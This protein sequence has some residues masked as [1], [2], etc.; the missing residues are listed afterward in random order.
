[1]NERP[2]L[3]ASRFARPSEIT[4]LEIWL[5]RLAMFSALTTLARTSAASARFARTVAP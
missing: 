5:F 4:L 1:M 2:A 3:S